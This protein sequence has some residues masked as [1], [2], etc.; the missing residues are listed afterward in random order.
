MD[1]S[2]LPVLIFS[3]ER[4]GTQTMQVTLTHNGI[5]SVDLH[6]ILTTEHNIKRMNPDDINDLNYRQYLTRSMI[7]YSKG[8]SRWKIITLIR[9]PIIDMC[10]ILFQNFS[11]Y[12]PQL[13]TLPDEQMFDGVMEYLHSRLTPGD[14]VPAYDFRSPF[15]INSW[16]DIQLKEVFGFDI[17]SVPFNRNAD[18]QIYETEHADILLIK[19][20]R[21]SDC[22]Q[23]ALSPFLGHPIT[24]LNNNNFTS[25]KPRAQMYDR[26]KKTL[27]LSPQNLEYI[28]SSSR[29][30]WHFYSSDQIAGF[31]RRWTDERE[32]SNFTKD[33]TPSRFGNTVIEHDRILADT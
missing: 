31:I 18:F 24:Q 14:H 10:S 26:V 28:Y 8:K 6:S 5:T 11:R 19:L 33:N 21:L 20:E 13:L 29:Y 32:L 1:I 2:N 3:P 25:N 15:Y 27:K 17:F 7:D 12:T 9:E 23:Q 22:F 16:F 4:T 30:L